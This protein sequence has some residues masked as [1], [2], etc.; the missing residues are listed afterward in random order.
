MLLN[1]FSELKILILEGRM[2]FT[3]LRKKNQQQNFIRIG[4]PLAGMDTSC[5]YI[6]RKTHT[7]WWCPRNDLQNQG[8]VGGEQLHGPCDEG[9]EVQLWLVCHG[10]STHGV[11]P[12]MATSPSV[13]WDG[14]NICSSG[15]CLLEWA[16]G[17]LIKAKPLD[18]AASLGRIYVTLDDMPPWWGWWS[19]MCVRQ[20]HK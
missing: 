16:V 13:V 4:K 14:V 18:S 9:W 2:W 7:T 12:E 19:S 5:L 15:S 10:G 6:P 11:S 17:Q 3:R 8:R 1:H 20:D